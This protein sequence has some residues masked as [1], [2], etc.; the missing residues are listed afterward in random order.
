MLR[1]RKDDGTWTDRD[2]V[3]AL[4]LTMH[5]NGLCSGC[6]LHRSV[7]HGLENVGRW[8]TAEEI[9]HGC[10]PIDSERDKESKETYPG[11]KLR[12]VDEHAL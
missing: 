9:C 10:A 4:A 7:T 8:G 12:L 2:R 6:G 5:E 1:G 11:K 3:M